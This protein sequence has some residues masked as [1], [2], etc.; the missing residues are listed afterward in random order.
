M[1][2]WNFYVTLIALR[3]SNWKV[4][5]A[6]RAGE[7]SVTNGLSDPCP[8]DQSSSVRDR[9]P[10]VQQALLQVRCSFSAQL[11]IERLKI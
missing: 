10:A 3:A 9:K 2:F 5:H 6:A 4:D 11:S 7:L 8:R 1:F